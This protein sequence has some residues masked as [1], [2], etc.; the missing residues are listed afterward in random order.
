MASAS[1]AERSQRDPALRNKRG[2]QVVLTFSQQVR[3]RRGVGSF[4]GWGQGPRRGHG[5]AP[6]GSSN[7]MTG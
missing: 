2:Q 3:V 6:R 1:A 5:L 4:E 7:L